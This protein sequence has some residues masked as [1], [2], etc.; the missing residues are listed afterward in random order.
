[1]SSSKELKYI[2]RKHLN[3]NIKH[4][5]NY[6]KSSD[7]SRAGL[8]DKLFTDLTVRYDNKLNYLDDNKD[9]IKKQTFL[10]KDK[11]KDIIQKKKILKNKDNYINV[12]K[13]KINTYINTEYYFRIITYI[14]CVTLIVLF[15]I[16][17]I[18]LTSNW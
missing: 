8:A 14:G 3:R 15:I 4:I 7:S 17:V 9:L 10:I 16:I 1:M 11:E 12:N 13:R 18:S 6:L 5:K 2:K